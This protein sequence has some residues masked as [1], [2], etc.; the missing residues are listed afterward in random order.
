MARARGTRE[1]RRGG[2]TVNTLIGFAVVQ[3]KADG[4]ESVVAQYPRE[5]WANEDAAFL[6][7]LGAVDIVVRPVSRD[8]DATE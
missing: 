6:Q 7:S 5:A 2:V 1:G 4:R 8:E 3:R